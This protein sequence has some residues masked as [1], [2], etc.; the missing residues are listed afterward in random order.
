[1][2]TRGKWGWM[3]N[4][5]DA[6]GTAGLGAGG[7]HRNHPRISQA[8]GVVGRGRLGST[9]PGWGK[10]GAISNTEVSTDKVRRNKQISLAAGSEWG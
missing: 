8:G 1:M 2:R 7:R 3:G 6:E 9:G 5:G 10:E 4:R